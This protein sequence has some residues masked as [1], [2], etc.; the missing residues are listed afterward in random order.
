MFVFER[1]ARSDLESERIEAAF[2]AMLQAQAGAQALDAYMRRDPEAA[3]H[4]FT[5]RLSSEAALGLLN[6]SVPLTPSSRP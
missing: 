6:A 3:G 1:L 2:Y 5:I 4:R